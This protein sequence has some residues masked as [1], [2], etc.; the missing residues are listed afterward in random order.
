[1]GTKLSERNVNSAYDSP[2]P[3]VFSLDLRACTSPTLQ[4]LLIH[5][6]LI[7]DFK[8]FLDKKHNRRVSKKEGT[9][10][11]QILIIKYQVTVNLLNYIKKNLF[12][13]TGTT[14][15]KKRTTLTQTQPLRLMQWPKD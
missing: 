3:L 1:M 13:E 4:V 10:S 6:K 7:L 11:I 14:R 5:Q 15:K 9:T 12:L 8:L 2:P